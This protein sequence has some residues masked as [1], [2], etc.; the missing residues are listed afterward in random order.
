MPDEDPFVNLLR[1]CTNL[2]ILVIVGQGLDPTELEIDLGGV[3]MPSLTT[4]TP[5]YLP[6]LR[7]LSL[8]SMHSSPLMLALLHSPLSSLKKLTVTPYHDIPYPTSLVSQ[9]I[10]AH[11]LTLSS[12]ILFTPKSWPTRLRPSPTNLLESAPNL[13]HL[14]LESPLPS[15]TLTQKHGLRILSIPRPT[16]EFWTIFERLLSLLPDLA[17]L[18]ARDV[19]W[20]KKGISSMAQEAGIQGEMRLWKRRLE[21]RRVR[22]L[23][24][25]WREHE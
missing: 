15:L 4:F 20:L 3:D 6:K 24:A 12:L 17:V 14:S 2:E 22:L 8:L 11:G 25:D 1:N 9:F 5:L 10:A 16:S 7:I 13:N 19:H 23:D 18:R 21:R